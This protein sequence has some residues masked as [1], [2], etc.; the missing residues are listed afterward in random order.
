[1]KCL[2]CGQSEADFECKLR[3]GLEFY[4]EEMLSYNHKAET[5]WLTGQFCREG[6]CSECNIYERWKERCDV[7]RKVKS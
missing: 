4:E 6:W 7:E 3:Q 1:M 2:I 5:C